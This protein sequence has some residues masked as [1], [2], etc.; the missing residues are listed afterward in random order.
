VIQSGYPASCSGRASDPPLAGRGTCQEL[1]GDAAPKLRFS[2]ISPHGDAGFSQEK[3]T[4][5][6]CCAGGPTYGL[7]LLIG[8]LS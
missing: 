8:P 1:D 5:R 6:V 7:H 3:K 4:A 2:G